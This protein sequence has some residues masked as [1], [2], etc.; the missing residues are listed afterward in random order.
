MKTTIRVAIVGCG[1]VGGSVASLLLKD[2]RLIGERSGVDVELA[3][4]HTRTFSRATDAGV[5]EELFERSLETLLE[6]RDID[7]VVELIG[8]LT[9]ARDIVL[10]AV[11]NGKHVVTANKALL[12]HHGTE[13]WEAARANGVCIG[14]EASTAGGIPVIRAITD[15]LLANRIDAVYGIVNGTSNYILTQMTQQGMGYADALAGAQRD[16]LAEADPSLDVNGTDS[17][18]KVAIMAA[19][20]FGIKVDFDAIPVS[21]IDLLESVDVT[22]GSDLGYVVKLLAVA[23]RTPDGV[24]PWVRP[25][26]IS[27]EHPLAWVSGPFNAVSIYGHATGHTLYYGRGAGGHPT[28]SAVISDILS[29]GMGTLPAVFDHTG[30]WQDRNKD[31]RQV[32]MAQTSS[33]FY[34]R[35][36][37]K[38]QPGVLA[39][40]ARIFGNH[41]ISIAS[42]LQPEV[43][44]DGAE[45]LVPIVITTHIS[46]QQNLEDALAHID[47]LDITG[48]RAACIPIIEEH[49]ERFGTTE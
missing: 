40:I 21:G 28:A 8:G 7:V 25:A 9:V 31:A 34:L 37:A 46:A 19:L 26:F 20:A 48:E 23:H 22:F 29:I 38:D 36:M 4:V 15:G 10:R 30:Y 17:A 1:T 32:P 49:A 24:T 13:L 18:H 16:G 2:R 41:S 39:E 11:A 47:A 44:E 14:F 27:R 35:I 42:M 33:R 6:R 5:P 12:A 43:T 45:T 3:A